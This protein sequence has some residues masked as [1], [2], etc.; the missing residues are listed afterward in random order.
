MLSTEAGTIIAT[1]LVRLNVPPSICGNIDPDSNI[2]NES[3]LQL[4]E[5][6][7]PKISTEAG[8]VMST[9]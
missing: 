2:T 7:L 5:H 1:N 6:P 4:E 9:N 8:I 3:E